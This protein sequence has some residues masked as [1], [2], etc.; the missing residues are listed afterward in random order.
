MG[1]LDFKAREKVYWGKFKIGPI[2]AKT[3]GRVKSWRRN[4]ERHL[5]Y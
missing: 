1:G 2:I 3:I 5:S 4:S